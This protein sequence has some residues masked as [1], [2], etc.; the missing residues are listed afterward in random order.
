MQTFIFSA[1]MNK[2]LQHNLKKF[3]KSRM[4]QEVA[5]TIGKENGSQLLDSK[6]IASG[7][8]DLIAKLDFRDPEPAVI[9]LSPKDGLVPTLQESKVECLVTDKV[10][11]YT[12]WRSF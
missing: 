8:D 12:S 10:G 1:T 7:K 5:S 2:D 3:R 11:F 6:L 9:D 4:K